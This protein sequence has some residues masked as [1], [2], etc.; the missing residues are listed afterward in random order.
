MFSAPDLGKMLQVKMLV[1]QDT[2]TLHFPL[3]TIKAEEAHGGG[4]G[5]YQPTL[6]CADQLPPSSW[7]SPRGIQGLEPKLIAQN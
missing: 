4:W 6:P 7:D 1:C 5:Q 2:G 3:R